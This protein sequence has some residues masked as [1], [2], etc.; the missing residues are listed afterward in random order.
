MIL[1]QTER[2]QGMW[3]R[4]VK[5]QKDREREREMKR[6]IK[7]S[8]FYEAGIEMNMPRRARSLSCSP[9]STSRYLAI[10]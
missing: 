8:R 6:Y 2:T 9:F 1:L 5:G 7:L 4:R 3:S 10:P